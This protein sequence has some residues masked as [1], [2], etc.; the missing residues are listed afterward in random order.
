MSTGF[1]GRF[2]LVTLA[3]GR[4]VCLLRMRRIQSITVEYDGARSTVGTLLALV[5]EMKKSAVLIKVY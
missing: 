3:L 5:E 4:L 1:R 2:K